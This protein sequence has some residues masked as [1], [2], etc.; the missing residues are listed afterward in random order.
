MLEFFAANSEKDYHPLLDVF[1]RFYALPYGPVELDIYEAMNSNTFPHIQF[2]GNDCRLELSIDSFEGLE[3]SIMLEMRKAFSKIKNM[4][5]NYITI[6]VFDLVGIT[7]KW[8]SWQVAYQV[9][10]LFGN[11]REAMSTKDICNSTVKAF[12]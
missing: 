7:H 2:D 9:A 11:K 1:D 4:G 5:A 12:I 6:S 10:E 3:K 8:T